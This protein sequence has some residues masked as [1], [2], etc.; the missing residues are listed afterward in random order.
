MVKVKVGVL[1]D[2]RTANGRIYPKGAVEAA[3]KKAGMRTIDVSDKGMV[4]VSIASH[5]S[6]GKEEKD[7]IVTWDSPESEEGK[8]KMTEEQQIDHG[9]LVR[10]NLMYRE[11][12]APYCGNGTCMYRAPF[13]GKQFQCP[14]C[15]WM[16]QFEP[17]FIE[18]YK[19]KW[20]K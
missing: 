13:N 11:G 10:N 4:A 12:Y 16:S 9:S 20:K 1:S 14:R 3:L 17:E 19:T 2:L 6:L 7:Q 8:K 18:I 15:N 5:V